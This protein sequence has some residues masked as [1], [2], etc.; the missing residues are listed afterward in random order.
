MLE[1]VFP[2]PVGGT[3]ITGANYI[4]AIQAKIHVA[5][6]PLVTDAPYAHLDFPNIKNVGDSAIWLGETTYLDGLLGKGPSYVASIQDFSEQRL[7]SLLPPE[8][9]I[10]LRGGGN[11]GDLWKGNQRFR[12]RI[13]RRYRDRPIIQMPQ[14]IHF[15]HAENL[16]EAKR[17]IDGHKHFILMVR[18]NNSR[19]YAEKHFDCRVVLCPD[20][21]FAMGPLKTIG[22]PIFPILAMLRDDK[23]K[24]AAD[25]AHPATNIPVED[26]I[27]EEQGPVTAAARKGVLAALSTFDRAAIRIGKYHAMAEQRLARGVRQISRGEIIITD[28]LHV[29]IVSLLLGKP[30][31]ALDN[32][33]GK[34]SG[35]RDAFPEPAG[36][37]FSTRSFAEAE[38]WARGLLSPGP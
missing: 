35:F 27:A 12:Q 32:S 16:E 28:R 22:E 2:P 4:A 25:G 8:G 14:S 37:T 23:E 19:E 20:M 15:D 7:E 9:T 11:F 1:V 18:D 31:A 24:A 30:H 5:I 21:A 26:W 36:L 29:H 38:A 6:N 34:I 33:Y 3:P 10:V 17:A 13:L